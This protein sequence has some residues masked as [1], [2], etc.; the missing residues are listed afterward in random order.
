MDTG[1]LLPIRA[2]QNA[3]MTLAKEPASWSDKQYR[4]GMQSVSAAARTAIKT[5]QWK[6]QDAT[7]EH[8]NSM[9]LCSKQYRCGICCIQRAIW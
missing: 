4:C 1:Q 5:R 7:K 9:H 2:E 3:K 8:E 6:A